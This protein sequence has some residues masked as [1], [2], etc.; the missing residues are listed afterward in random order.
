MSCAIDDVQY[1]QSVGTQESYLFVVDSAKR[2]VSAFLH[3]NNYEATFNEPFYNTYSISLIGAKIPRTQYIVD[4]N[5]NVL[6]YKVGDGV[7]ST[8]TVVPGDYTADSLTTALNALLPDITVSTIALQSR[9]LFTAV[10]DFAFDM[11]LS[12][13][14]RVLGFSEPIDP[15]NTGYTYPAT[16]HVGPATNPLC[17]DVFQSIAAPASVSILVAGPTPAEPRGFPASTTRLVFLAPSSGVV[18]TLKLLVSSTAALS[19]PVE[20]QL[21]STLQTVATAVIAVPTSATP[22]YVTTQLPCALEGSL[23]YVL[24]FPT[25]ITIVSVYGDN[26]TAPQNSDGSYTTQLQT[27]SDAGAWAAVSDASLCLVFELDYTAGSSVKQVVA[28]GVY[29]LTGVRYI[30]IQCKELTDHLYRNRAYDN[31]CAG[32]GVV[33]LGVYGF[34]QQSYDFYSYPPRTFHP[35]TLRKLTLTFVSEGTNILYDF[36]GIDHQLTFVIRYYVASTTPQPLHMLN[37]HYDPDPSN[38]W[39]QEFQ[40]QENSKSITLRSR[41]H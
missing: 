24:S 4:F 21:A 8:L 10:E 37:R 12:S 20:L 14:R 16:Y 19:L 18:T 6:T 27:K 36:K 5:N 9:F 13:I 35:C 28:P 1:L 25:T 15:A 41:R 2:D 31:W 29:D 40:E 23:A 7:W 34:Q 26:V 39:L 38:V 11:T 30:S 22:I 3:P 33:D 17:H 32:L